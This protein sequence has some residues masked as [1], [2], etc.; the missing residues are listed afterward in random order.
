MVNS[1]CE[2]NIIYDDRCIPQITISSNKEILSKII[3][4]IERNKEKYEPIDIDNDIN[5]KLKIY[6]IGTYDKKNDEFLYRSLDNIFIEIVK[7][8]KKQ[9]ELDINV[10]I[11]TPCYSNE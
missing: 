6:S 2:V 11:Y 4:H 10:R 1:R 8:L 5:N 9:S 3:G 7:F